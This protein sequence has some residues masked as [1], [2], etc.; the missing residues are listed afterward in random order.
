MDIEGDE[1]RRLSSTNEFVAAPHIYAMDANNGAE[2]IAPFYQHGSFSSG[3]LSMVFHSSLPS[4]AVVAVA[5][6]KDSYATNYNS[7][8]NILADTSCIYEVAAPPRLPTPRLPAPRQP[9][10][11]LTDAPLSSP[12]CPPPHDTPTTA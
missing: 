8:A 1:F 2:Q 7:D 5:G 4:M 9:T 10:P 11:R 3:A 6:C 12:P